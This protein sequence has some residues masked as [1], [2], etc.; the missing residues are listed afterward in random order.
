MD[1]Q[2]GET[3]V[4]VEEGGLKKTAEG[5]RVSEV[6]G[7]ALPGTMRINLGVDLE[8]LRT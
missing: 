7:A 1:L 4:G 3:F 8:W 6:V 2:H 5:A